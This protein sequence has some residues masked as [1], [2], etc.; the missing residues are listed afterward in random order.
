MKLKA[1]EGPLCGKPYADHGSDVTTIWD[2]WC[3]DE[4]SQFWRPVKPFASKDWP[5]AILNDSPRYAGAEPTL[6]MLANCRS[7]P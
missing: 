2:A 1:P 6:D 3:D 7:K 5:F 4:C